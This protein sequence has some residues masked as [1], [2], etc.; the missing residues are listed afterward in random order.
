MDP[1]LV[2]LQQQFQGSSGAA[3]AAATDEK[4]PIPAKEA[5][6]PTATLFQMPGN[7]IGSHILLANNNMVPTTQG[8]NQ[9][10]LLQQYFY[11]NYLQQLAAQQ[12][13]QQQQLRQANPA[14]L[15][16]LSFSPVQSCT[17]PQTVLT[18]E[19]N[20]KRKSAEDIMA[21]P[22]KQTIFPS[23]YTHMATIPTSLLKPEVVTPTISTPTSI[24]SE[25]PT[26]IKSE[27]VAPHSVPVSV[28]KMESSL[29]KTTIATA[30]S[31]NVL[32]PEQV[33]LFQHILSLYTK[34]TETLPNQV[35]STTPMPSPT[36]L[37]SPVGMYINP[38]SCIQSSQPQESHKESIEKEKEPTE[39]SRIV[40]STSPNSREK[41][42]SSLISL[43]NAPLSRNSSEENQEEEED[44]D[45]VD[46]VGGI[47][48]DKTTT[49]FRSVQRKAHIDFY[50]KLKS[51]RNRERLLKCHLC[52]AQVENS[53]NGLRSH[54]H[55]HSNAP[56]F[57]CK[58]CQVGF[59]ERH[60]IFE[61]LKEKHPGRNAE[62]FEDRRDMVHLGEVL[63]NCF[64]KTNTKSRV[65]YQ[66]LLKKITQFASKEKLSN[67]ECQLCKVKVSVQRQNIVQH[68]HSHPA[69]RC[70]VC[71]FTCHE[72][73]EQLQHSKKEHNVAEPKQSADYNVCTA[74][75]ALAGTFEQ[76]FS[77]YLSTSESTS[78][79]Q[80]EA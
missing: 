1:Q 78:M 33:Q 16:T 72:E 70:K 47:P 64:S 60:R 39:C 51:F 48:G 54:I 68:L 57:V 36:S 42:P 53:D 73:A 79:E 9:A 69:F 46:V 28:I 22:N 65:S 13:Q 17:I 38:V 75:E 25:F 23:Y 66:D 10:S 67:I 45:V 27:I 19:M 20:R 6:A 8:Q 62:C 63:F 18:A 59:K 80:H 74:Q 40:N 71:K 21:L 52:Q 44:L 58:I 2:F 29:P 24:K 49:V 56:L 7:L 41:S 32:T 12:Q 55:L 50:R 35:E 30:K 76:C 77:A 4:H 3:T 11:A 61:H 43:L 26:T 5:N 15:P 14:K 34:T 37:T 31:E